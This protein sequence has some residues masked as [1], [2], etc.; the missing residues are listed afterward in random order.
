[1]L[2]TGVTQPTLAGLAHP[3]PVSR[4]GPLTL[5]AGKHTIKVQLATTEGSEWVLGVLLVDDTGAPMH[6]CAYTGGA[7]GSNK[8]PGLRRVRARHVVSVCREKLRDN[9]LGKA[10]ERL[11]I[12]GDARKRDDDIGYTRIDE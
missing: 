10:I 11:L 6:R 5:P 3:W 9:L 12:V 4:F 7:W 8:S 2:E 1:M